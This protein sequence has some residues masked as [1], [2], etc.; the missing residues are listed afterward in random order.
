MHRA[1]LA[2]LP[3]PPVVAALIVAECFVTLTRA[4]SYPFLAV[5]LSQRFGL[6]PFEIGLVLGAGPIFG[7]VVALVAG[8]WSDRIGRWPLLM[9]AI[10]ASAIG[11]LGLPLSTEVWQ[12]F[13]CNLLISG[14]NAVREPVVRALISDYTAEDRCFTAF[15][16]RYL[17]INVAW[18]GGPLLGALA[19]ATHLPGLLMA[20]GCG[21]LAVLAMIG[22]IAWRA[23]TAAEQPTPRAVPHSI[24]QSLRTVAADR[25]L[26]WFVLGA[27]MTMTVH[28]QI[29]VTLLQHFKAI[30]DNGE[31]MLALLMT[32]NAITVVLLSQPVSRIVRRLSPFQA[33]AI[34]ALLTAA[35]TLGFGLTE[36]HALLILAMVVLSIGEVMISPAEFLMIDGIAP[37]SRRGAYH[38]AMGF[39][40]IGSA[41]GPAIGGWLLV[42][43]GGAVA[44]GVLAAIALLAIVAFGRGKAAPPPALSGSAVATDELLVPLPRSIRGIAQVA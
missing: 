11:F 30:T 37:A 26:T 32:A 22:W 42:A 41:A 44:F 40:A 2:R 25:R 13:A 21:Q 10:L 28:G 9:A 19:A 29:S 36:N 35:G 5:Y 39:N 1:L 23:R 7:M 38:G 14:C 20:S 31:A 4:G 6:N 33:V 43:F 16:H 18:A 17:A 3:Y 24:L 15:S 8:A 27:I 34:G 12:I